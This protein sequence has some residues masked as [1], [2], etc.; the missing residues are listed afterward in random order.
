MVGNSVDKQVNSS[1][2]QFANQNVYNA[3]YDTDYEETEVNGVALISNNQNLCE[4][5]PVNHQVQSGNIETKALVNCG[6][7][8][9]TIHKN[10]T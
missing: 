1:S 7:G 9:T 2:N 4:V 6:S 5:E 3:K 10:F 8:C